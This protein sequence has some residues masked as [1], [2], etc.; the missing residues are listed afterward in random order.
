MLQR[1][2]IFD[3]IVVSLINEE[4]VLKALDFALENNVHSMKVS[5][6]LE[7]VEKFKLEGL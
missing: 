7:S 4:L 2:K 1:L 5:S 3:E 6:F